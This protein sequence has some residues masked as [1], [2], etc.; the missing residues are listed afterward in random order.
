MITSTG[1]FKAVHGVG[2]GIISARA[3]DNKERIDVRD[4]REEPLSSAHVRNST[5]HTTYILTSRSSFSSTM[6]IRALDPNH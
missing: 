5:D 1:D 2:P 4:T 6:G 3:V